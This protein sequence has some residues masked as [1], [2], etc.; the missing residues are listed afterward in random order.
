M[1]SLTSCA[2]AMLLAQ[3]AEEPAPAEPELGPREERRLDLTQVTDEPSAADVQGEPTADQAD[4]QSVREDETNE[5][6]WV[7]R[8]ILFPVRMVYEVPGQ[9]LKGTFWLVERY[10]V[11]DVYQQIFFNEDGTFGIFPT[12]LFE[13]GFGL[14][15]GA[16]LIYR[17]IF[18]HGESLSV[19]AG[20]GGQ[21]RQT[22]LGQFQSGA[23]FGS[24]FRLELLGG[25]DARPRARFFGIGNAGDIDVPPP[26]LPIDPID[27]DFALNS[28]YSEQRTRAQADLRFFFTK[29]LS[30]TAGMGW[31]VQS[32]GSCA[33]C[34]DADELA[35]VSER[36]S[37]NIKDVY[38]T[39]ALVG[40]N[41]G[42]SSLTG[43]VALSYDSREPANDFIPKP[44]PSRGWRANV[45]GGRT[46]GFYDDPSRFTRIGG[47]LTR[48]FNIFRGDRTLTLRAYYETVIGRIR[49]IPF[50]AYPQLGGNFVLR[51]EQIGRYRDRN[52]ASV[53]A[54]YM[55]SL[56]KNLSSF[57]FIDGGRVWR[58]IHEI[59]FKDTHLGGGFGIQ[60]HTMKT[61][62]LRMMVGY[63]GN[64]ARLAVSVDPLYD[65]A[66]RAEW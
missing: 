24:R 7:P 6:L 51:A 26:T 42:L 5:L 10:R 9:A 35:D 25:N 46:F 18:G 41:Q 37:V 20:Y 31:L 14:N 43:S 64:Q 30:A 65:I 36:Q 23:L 17:N 54:E 60:A 39:A 13:T 49:D 45:F 15:V 62:L 21:F 40:F 4:G 59:Q 32:F 63:N 58:D 12:A 29:R 19:R 66:P 11:Q 61:F 38:D 52:V 57:V 3:V 33:G 34:Q 56:N 8:V 28:R 53:S 48:V 16:R 22:L 2:L 27:Q 50:V 1:L 47:D 55:W 44:T